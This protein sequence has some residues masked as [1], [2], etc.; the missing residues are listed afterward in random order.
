MRTTIQRRAAQVLRDASFRPARINRT[1]ICP[2]CS[3]TTP[4][5]AQTTIRVSQP[6]RNRRSL[7]TSC[8]LRQAEAAPAKESFLPQTHYDYFPLTLGPDRIP[9]KAPFKVDLKALRREFL[10]LQ[11]KA[12]PDLAPAG[13]KRQ[14]EALSSRINEAY[15][16]LQNPLLRAQYLLSLRGID[17]AEDETAKV[18]DPDLLMEVLETRETI[19]EAEKEED[20]QELKET[21]E[22][23]I[24]KSEEI[25][26]RAFQE[27][28]MDKAKEEAVRLRYWVNI[29]ESI[30]G[31]E[32]GKPVVLV[33]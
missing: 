18:E 5:L 30:D 12:H 23:R 32:K 4:H 15:K 27:D 1:S 13:K 3:S 7:T 33:H 16:T 21:N 19:E 25:L 22:V 2:R 29:R 28:N 8:I 6:S 10:Q 17:V 24:E 11:S 9:P 20:L 14:A 31:W 26:S